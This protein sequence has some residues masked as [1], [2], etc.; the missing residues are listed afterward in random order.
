MNQELTV[1]HVTVDIDWQVIGQHVMV[2][3]YIIKFTI[4]NNAFL[5]C[6]DIDECLDNNGGCN[7]ECT[8]TVG[9]FECSC[10]PGYFLSDDNLTC[11]GMNYCNCNS[12]TQCMSQVLFLH[13]IELHYLVSKLL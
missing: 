12:F 3:S 11:V 5:N 6:S 9:S 8:N 10:I 1:A 7:Q 4:S 2:G 13:S